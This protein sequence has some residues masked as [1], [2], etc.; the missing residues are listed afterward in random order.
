MNLYRMFQV[1]RSNG[2]P[3][4]ITIIPTCSEWTRGDEFEDAIQQD[5]GHS[6]YDPNYCTPFRSEMDGDN[7]IITYLPVERLQFFA[8]SEMVPH[9]RVLT[10]LNRLILWHPPIIA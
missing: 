4:E 5:F 1:H 8:M 9:D 10:E 6:I 2:S 3:Q 7:I